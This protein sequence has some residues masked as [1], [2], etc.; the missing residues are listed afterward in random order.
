MTYLDYYNR[1][2][3]HTKTGMRSPVEFE[4]RPFRDSC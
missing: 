3:R 1:T 2:R 4:A